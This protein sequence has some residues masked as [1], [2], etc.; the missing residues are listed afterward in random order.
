MAG[1]G[2]S[3]NGSIELSY[4]SNYMLEY[5]LL[6]TGILSGAIPPGC[7]VFGARMGAC[8]LPFFCDFFLGGGRY[9]EIPR[10]KRRDGMNL[11]A[12]TQWFTAGKWEEV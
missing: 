6:E 12:F 11:K 7:R 10:V 1:P 4:P 8:F 5:Q 2:G 3:P 9:N